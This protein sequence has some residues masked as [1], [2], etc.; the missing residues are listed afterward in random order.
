MT[1]IYL[2]VCC[3]FTFL[4][5]GCTDGGSSKNSPANANVPP[6]IQK[7]SRCEAYELSAKCLNDSMQL[8]G[9]YLGYQT[10]QSIEVRQSEDLMTALSNNGLIKIEFAKPIGLPDFSD[11]VYEEITFVAKKNGQTWFTFSTTNARDL[12]SESLSVSYSN[13]FFGYASDGKMMSVTCSNGNRYNI[14]D[15]SSAYNECN[16]KTLFP[17]TNV[18]SF[19]YLSPNQCGVKIGLHGIGQEFWFISIYK[20]LSAVC[21]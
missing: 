15:I 11:S 3:L 17:F 18:P 13:T 21:N 8:F 7:V 19:S 12:S 14:D 2:K 4:V 9:T 5:A 10:G 1:K 16:S 20:P 6:V